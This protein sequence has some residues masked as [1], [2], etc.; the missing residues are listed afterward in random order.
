MTVLFPVNLGAA[1]EATTVFGEAA[2]FCIQK[3]YLNCSTSQYLSAEDCH[4]VATRHSVSEDMSP[5]QLRQMQGL[6]DIA[7]NPHGS[8]IGAA[9]QLTSSGS[10]NMSFYNTPSPMATQVTVCSFLLE[11]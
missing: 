9:G 6:K 7:A 2:S 3:Q 4:V 11:S 10:S 1:E 5:R 8:S